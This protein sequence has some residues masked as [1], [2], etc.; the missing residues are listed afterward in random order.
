M[1]LGLEKAVKKGYDNQV[2]KIENSKSKAVGSIGNKYD[3]NASGSNNEP[4][5]SVKSLISSKLS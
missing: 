2:V 5:K 3:E 4:P 1:F